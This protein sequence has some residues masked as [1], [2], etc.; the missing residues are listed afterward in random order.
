V[1]IEDRAE[2]LLRA[3]AGSDVRALRELC[4]DDVV[5]FGTDRGERWAGMASLLPAIEAM[6]VLE[7]NAR[8]EGPI[9]AGRNWAAGIAHYTAAQMAPTDVRVTL[10]FDEDGRLAHAHFS[11]AVDVS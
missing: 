6:R 10:V 2:R 11:V 1:T 3:F 9:V 5:V 8:W 7:L 4:R